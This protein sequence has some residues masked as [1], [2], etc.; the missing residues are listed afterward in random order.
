MCWINGWVKPF[1]VLWGKL[2][3]M[4]AYGFVEPLLKGICADL[5]SCKVDDLS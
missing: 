2:T 1:L 4:G 5:L 3:F